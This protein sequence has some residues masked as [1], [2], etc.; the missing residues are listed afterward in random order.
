MKIKIGELIYQLFPI[1]VKR[2]SAVLFVKFPVIFLI[3]LGIEDLLGE[4]VFPAFVLL[5]VVLVGGLV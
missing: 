3:G 5:V 1:S 2:S 4:V